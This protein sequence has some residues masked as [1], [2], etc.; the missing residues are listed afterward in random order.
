MQRAS[1]SSGRKD[2]RRIEQR[3]QPAARPSN[4][5]HETAFHTADIRRRWFQTGRI[6]FDDIGRAVYKQT[7]QF[8]AIAHN[9]D[10]ALVAGVG[11]PEFELAAQ[12]DHTHDLAPQVHHSQ[13][14]GRPAG[15]LR[16]TPQAH[17]FFDDRCVKG[18]ERAAHVECR[19]EQ[20]PGLLSLR[21]LPRIETRLHKVNRSTPRRSCSASFDNSWAPLC[22]CVLPSADSPAARVTVSMTA[23][24]CVL[25]WELRATCPA[26]PR[27]P[28][29][30]WAMLPAMSLVTAA[31]CSI[32][33]AIDDRS[34]EH[35]SE[36]QSRENIVCRLLL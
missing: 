31:C 3:R 26:A 12:I 30:A 8:G 2:R 34:E 17:H 11:R 7:H 6:Q 4:A 32:A 33:V 36:L 5:A 14:I 28:E 15:N 23:A 9:I 35:T 29:D 25:T 24:I 20:C 1:S 27:T 16:G 21:R 22:T 18:A 10:A 19:G 13:Q